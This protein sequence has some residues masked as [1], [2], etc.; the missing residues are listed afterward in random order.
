[1]FYT[2]EFQSPF[3]SSGFYN[4]MSTLDWFFAPTRIKSDDYEKASKEFAN[5]SGL[6]RQTASLG[7]GCSDTLNPAVAMADQPGMVAMG[8][9]GMGGGCRVDENTELKW[10]TPGTARV[11]GPKQ[12]WARPFATTPNLGG[13][14]PTAVEDES[15]LIFSAPPRNRKEASTIMDKAIPNFY[16]PLIQIKQSEFSNPTNWV[17]NW[18]RG[19]DSTRLVQTKREA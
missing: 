11:K 6:T 8:G 10:G 12:L 9:Y 16:Q 17:E 7:A 3:F 2:L 18:T 1:M 15:G 4:K 13:G 14:E 5:Q 19:G